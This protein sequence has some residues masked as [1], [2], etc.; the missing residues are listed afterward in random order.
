MLARDG[1]VWSGQRPLLPT[2]GA[3]IELIDTTSSAIAAE[4]V[5]ARTRAGSPAMGMVMTLVIVVAEEDAEAA[6]ETARRPRTS[7]P[8]GCSA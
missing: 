1:R 4:F 8:P 2:R 3:M 7:T 6:M 5:R